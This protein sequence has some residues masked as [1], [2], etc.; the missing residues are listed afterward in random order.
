MLLSKGLCKL[1]GKRLKLR[2]DVKIV[3]RQA[4]GLRIQNKPRQ[5]PRASAYFEH[6]CPGGKV[7]GCQRPKTGGDVLLCLGLGIVACRGG[8]KALPDQC[9]IHVHSTVTKGISGM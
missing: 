9:C 4:A 6:I 7:R 2:A 8:A 5:Q 1:L 3:Q